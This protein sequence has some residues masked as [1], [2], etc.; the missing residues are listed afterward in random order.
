MKETLSKIQQ[1]LG[2]VIEIRE[3]IDLVGIKRK[4]VNEDEK[5]FKCVMQRI[6]S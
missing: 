5:V 1:S 3:I 6:K 2:V 4:C